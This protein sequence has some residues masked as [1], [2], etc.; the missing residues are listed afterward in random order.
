MAWI[1]RHLGHGGKLAFHLH[2]V[3]HH[4]PLEEHQRLL[5]ERLELYRLHPRRPPPCHPQDAGGDLCCPRAGRQDPLEGLVARRGVAVAE[6]EFGVVEDR[7]QG[8]V[9]LV[10]RRAEEVAERGG[11]PGLKDFSAEEGQLGFVPPRLGLELTEGPVAPVDRC[12]RDGGRSRGAGDRSGNGR[13]SVGRGKL[14]GHAA[15]R[16]RRERTGP[17]PPGRFSPAKALAVSDHHATLLKPPLPRRQTSPPSPPKP[18]QCPGRTTQPRPP[19][20]PD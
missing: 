17:T 14:S 9:E 20:P 6:A 12:R 1:G 4:L 3:F 8:I 18:A 11:L 16:W 5:D 15:N 13:G 10:R 19:A 2:P 7:G